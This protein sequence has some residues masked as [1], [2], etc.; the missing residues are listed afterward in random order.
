MTG[1]EKILAA[2]SPQGTRHTPIIV[3]Y[4]EI[5][6]RDQWENVTD[7]PWWGMHS[8][9]IDMAVQVHRDLLAVTGEDRVRLWMSAPRDDRRRYSI[10]GID[11][12]R[13]KRIDTVTGEVEELLR[14]PPGGFV[15]HG[16]EGWSRNR[17]FTS[18][19]QIDEALPLPP[20]ETAES[21]A[22]DGRSD[23]PRRMLAEFGGEKMPWTQLPSP[24]DPLFKLWGYEGLLIA[25]AEQP[26]LVEYACRR[27]VQCTLNR[28]AT[29]KA[30]GVELIW[31]EEGASDQISPEQHRR[32]I[33]PHMQD[34]TAALREAGL[35]SLY[36]FTGNPNDRLDVLLASGADALSLEEGKK[37]YAIDL[38]E[39]VRK[40]D[41]RMAL[42]GNLD[43]MS[44]MEHGSDDEV[45]TAVARQ[46][47]AGRINGG[48]F[49]FGYG[50][51]ITPGTPVA[52]VRMVADTVHEL[53]P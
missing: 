29:W 42:V 47:E 16:D 46:L 48:R 35:K 53:A 49:L 41:G 13:A 28:M 11:A 33:L 30:A 24:W 15:S 25:C 22:A 9:D 27:V 18:R 12:E 39:I 14:P 6:M 8:Q 31:I 44:L 4:S 26:D 52:R 19:E 32:L 50:S 17:D 34:L 1:R 5:F 40:V 37:G 23:K 51:P 7:V 21:L 3:C 36:Y 10:E 2:L 43:A 45:R 20:A 38:G